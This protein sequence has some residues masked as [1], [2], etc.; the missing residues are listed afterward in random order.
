MNIVDVALKRYATKKFNPE[1]TISKPELEQ[2][3][4]LLRLSPSS[5]NSQPWHFIVA[6]SKEGKAQIAKGAEGTYQANHAKI[7]DA[8]VVVLY[9]AKTEITDEHLQMVTDQED[10]DGRFANQEAK[11]L[12]MKVRRFYADLHR[13]DW[14]D[15]PCW[16]QK[17]V[18]LNMG[19]LLLGAGAMGLDAV[20]IEGIDLD[21]INQEF[22]LVN[23]G[24]TA[25]A[26]VALGHAAEDDFNAALPKS[27]LPVERVFSL[28]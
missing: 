27:R 22:D 9:C 21:L 10:K 25:V 26:V 11:D 16:T 8:S 13:V 3:L 17:Q 19:S 2:I 24:L 18:Y 20:P 4:T 7:I 15:V 28:I 12:A 14:Q 23:K 5:V 1:K 6:Q